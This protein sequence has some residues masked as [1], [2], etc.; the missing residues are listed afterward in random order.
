MPLLALVVDDVG[1]TWSHLLLLAKI[2]LAE[3]VQKSELVLQERTLF[4]TLFAGPPPR[5]TPPPSKSTP[6]PF[7]VMVLF[8]A[9]PP[10][11]VRFTRPNELLPVIELRTTT[12]FVL[13]L[14]LT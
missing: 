11:I 9:L 14:T 2:E 6:Y 10:G 13:P 8:S 1:G 7:P 3:F 4:P 12:W 5:S